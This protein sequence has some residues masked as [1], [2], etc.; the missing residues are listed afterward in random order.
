MCCNCV[1]GKPVKEG[2][3]REFKIIGGR[4]GDGYKRVRVVHRILRVYCW[5]SDR[6]YCWQEIF[7]IRLQYYSI[8][9]IGYS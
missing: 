5:Q 2:V 8:L 3:L 7:R 1:R 6:L 9:R 4:I